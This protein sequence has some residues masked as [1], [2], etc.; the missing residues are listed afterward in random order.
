[1]TAGRRRSSRPALRRRARAGASRGRG[2]CRRRCRR[3]RLEEC[4]CLAWEV[5][6][7]AASI[8]GL[9][10]LRPQT[11]EASAGALRDPGRYQSGDARLRQPPRIGP[12]AES[13]R[14]RRS[15]LSRPP[16]QQ[17]D[18]MGPPKLDESMAIRDW[19][20]G[21]RPREKLIAQG[22]RSL[23]EAEL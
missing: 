20:K 10:S 15:A 13:R 8:I 1:R 5:S 21:E 11:S 22:A 19:P 9:R 17:A 4:V 16:L 18:T 3:S 12:T 23:S 2:T 14:W 7:P 6:C